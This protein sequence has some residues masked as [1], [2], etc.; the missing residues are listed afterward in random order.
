MNKQMWKIILYVVLL[1]AVLIGVQQL[2]QSPM[3]RFVAVDGV[4]DL[5]DGD[6]S[7]EIMYIDEAGWEYYPAHLYTPADFRS[8]GTVDPVYDDS[9]SLEE[10][11]TYRLRAKLPQDILYAVTGKSFPFSQR[12]FINGDLAGEVGMPDTSRKD[13]VTHAKT[14]GYYFR[15]HDGEVEFVFQVANFN[16]RSGGYNEEMKLG[17]PEL[18]SGYRAKKLI[19]SCLLV[20]GFAF[21]FLYFI[22]LYIFFSRRRYFLFLALASL[23]TA[24]RMTFLDDKYVMVPFPDLSWSFA[25]RA[26][27]LCLVLFVAF[28][29]LYFMT[30]YPG[31]LNRFFVAAVVGLSALYGLAIVFTDTLYFT[32]LFK[33]YTV[34]W[35][36]ASAMTLWKMT[37]Q[38]R[39]RDMHTVLIFTGLVVFI[40]TAL[41]DEMTYHFI[42]HARVYN[43]L[44]AGVLVGMFTNMIALTLNFAE[45]E[46]ALLAAKNRQKA[47]NVANRLLDRLNRMKTHFMANMSHEMKT[48]L[49][50]MSVHAQLSKALLSA[51]ADSEEVTQSLDTI[52]MESKRLARMV[53][54]MLDLMSMQESESDMEEID[55][56]LLLRNVAEAY[57]ALL[58]KKG[59]ALVLDIQDSLPEVR[60]NADMLTQVLLNLFANAN[61]YTEHGRINVSAAEDGGKVAVT[62]RDTGTGV[63]PEILAHA[64][65]RRVA[66]KEG[67]GTGLGLSICKSIIERHNGTIGIDNVDKRDGGGTVVR[68]VL[69]TKAKGEK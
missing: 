67:G 43:T 37:L 22:G 61:R 11:G 20:G 14:Y 19:Y 23:A 42:Y 25:I 30:L 7:R 69:P 50:V 64:F 4:V 54:G 46:N 57:D 6:L 26:E 58:E 38:L 45:V 28:L 5:T 13:T 66:E 12:V 68:F 8:G 9:S 55:I 40:A 48:P 47:L 24:V 51:K 56:G 15:P 49:T 35:V 63:P 59:N 41:F 27:Y 3:R 21:V 39:Y 65:A 36:A 29:Q 32:G 52:S 2:T 33:W 1:L 53:G 62:V 17:E 34:V 31:M 60:G 16:H 10:Y 18:V 44:A